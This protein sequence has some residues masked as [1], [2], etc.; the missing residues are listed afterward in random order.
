VIVSYD[1]V[2]KTKAA[3][4]PAWVDAMRAIEGREVG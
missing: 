4:P 2:Q 1:Y 3:L